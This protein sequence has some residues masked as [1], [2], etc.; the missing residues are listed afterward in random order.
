MTPNKFKTVTR[1]MFAQVTQKNADLLKEEQRLRQ[2]A[3]ES[4]KVAAKLVGKLLDEINSCGLK[5]HLALTSA[6]SVSVE[7]ETFVDYSSEQPESFVCDLKGYFYLPAYAQDNYWKDGD[8]LQNLSYL[9]DYQEM[10]RQCK[11]DE[12]KKKAWRRFNDLLQTLK[13]IDKEWQKIKTVAI[14]TRIEIYSEDNVVLNM[15]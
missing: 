5:Y 4:I 9:Q 1:N 15:H 12:T 13:T 10:M 11:T 2:E 7:A 6:V 8:Y 3:F 14:S